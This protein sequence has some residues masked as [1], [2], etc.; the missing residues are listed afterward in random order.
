MAYPLPL[1]SIR[2]F[3]GRYYIKI[4]SSGDRKHKPWRSFERW[5]WERANGPIPKNYYIKHIDGDRTNIMLSNL[6][7]TTF[8]QE[9]ARRMKDKAYS[10]RKKLSIS[11]GLHQARLAGR[12]LPNDV[13]QIRECVECGYEDKKIPK[14]PKCNSNSFAIYTQKR[15][16]GVG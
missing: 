16:K 11:K 10:Q 3:N 13:L 2:L 9:E 4:H 15:M 6:V 14:C 12:I 8:G 1:G 5:F 7:L